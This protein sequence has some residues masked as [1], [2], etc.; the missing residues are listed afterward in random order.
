MVADLSISLKQFDGIVGDHL[1]LPRFACCLPVLS[2][3]RL[4]LTDPLPLPHRPLAVPVRN[5]GLRTH[6]QDRDERV[7][8]TH[9]QP[10]GRPLYIKY[11][12]S[13]AMWPRSKQPPVTVTILAARHVD[14][15][16]KKCEKKN[17]SNKQKCGV[18]R[19]SPGDGGGR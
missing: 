19:T 16:F 5:F 10:E 7:Q 4:T 14:P 11:I 1:D 18:C 3:P 13:S 8:A 6:E 12:G 2:A 17:A 9:R 15:F